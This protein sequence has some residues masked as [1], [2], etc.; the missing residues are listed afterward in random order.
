[1]DR[2]TWMKQDQLVTLIRGRAFWGRELDFVVVVIN[3]LLQFMV[4][5]SLCGYTEGP[6]SSFVTE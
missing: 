4:P 3:T 5:W 1:M 6:P 2:S